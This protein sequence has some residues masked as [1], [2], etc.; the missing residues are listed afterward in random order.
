[1]L[2]VRMGVFLVRIIRNRR[3]DEWMGLEV[4]GCSGLVR[5]F[6]LGDIKYMYIS[7]GVG[8]L[9]LGVG[10]VWSVPMHRCC[11]YCKDSWKSK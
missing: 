2:V 7:V 8:M 11:L 3:H 6:D 1:M 9:W 10:V 4:V 5:G